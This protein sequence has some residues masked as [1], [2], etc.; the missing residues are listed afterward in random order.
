MLISILTLFPDQFT[1]IFS[2]S[3][4]K[5]A[6]EK[7]LMTIRI[8]NIRDFATD[9]HKSVDDRPYGGGVG[10]IL[11]VDIL[12]RAIAFARSSN[13][14]DA[15]VVLLDPQGTQYHQSY[16]R[17]LSLIQHLILV[18]GHYEGVDE[19]IRNLVDD[20]I[21]I[22]DYILTGGEIP[23]MVIVDSVTRLLPGVFAKSSV[24]EDES[25]SQVMPQLE[26]PQYT[27]PEN[28]RN[29]KVPDILISGDHQKIERW[30][31][32]QSRKRTK[33]LRPDLFQAK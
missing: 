6:Q 3:I 17:K 28:Y 5:R 20:Q 2:H 13:T 32:L 30:R 23:A 11:K 10:M 26:Y 16:A 29:R 18:C 12:D 8:I 19:R 22:G 9:K 21:S 7:N 14:H 4:I 1:N 24:T 15:K 33:N 31:K 25:F 27:R